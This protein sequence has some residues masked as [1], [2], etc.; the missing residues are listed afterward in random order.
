MSSTSL[1]TE[2][3]NRNKNNRTRGHN[4][5]RK[6]A[7]DL[8]EIYDSEE[9]LSAYNGDC[10]GRPKG[11]KRKLVEK[12]V[13]QRGLQSRNAREPDLV[14]PS[15]WWFELGNGSFTLQSKYN[16]A[17]RDLSAQIKRGNTAFKKIAAIV[18]EKNKRK[19]SVMLNAR[20]FTEIVKYS[21]KLSSVNVVLDYDDFVQLL[22]LEAQAK[23]W[24][25][26]QKL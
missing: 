9:F 14:T 6:L 22:K 21:D 8:R 20:N 23:K 15:D 5:E 12:S 3:S 24:K 19:I 25:S 26:D 18:K 1:K 2:Q 16:Q 4:F 10:R 13:V 17:Q 11:F 7:Q